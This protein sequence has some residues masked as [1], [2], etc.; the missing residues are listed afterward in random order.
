MLRKFRLGLCAGLIA[1]AAA[2]EPNDAS[3]HIASAPGLVGNL[4]FMFD[5]PHHESFTGQS[6]V[7]YLS[8]WSG[9]GA[10]A[11]GPA[12]PWR[13]DPGQ[14]GREHQGGPEFESHDGPH[15]GPDRH[16]EWSPGQTSP[17]P[18]PSTYALMGLGLLLM[19]MFAHRRKIH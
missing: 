19:G 4:Q 16:H 13:T 12:R 6:G 15:Q 17:N 1:S 18:E 5:Q 11:H 9:A 14:H 8:R 3:Q 2:A 10:R 7:D